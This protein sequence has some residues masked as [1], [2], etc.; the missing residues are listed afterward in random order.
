MQEV[1]EGGLISINHNEVE[2]VSLGNNL[3]IDQSIDQ[4]QELV[5]HLAACICPTL[6]PETPSPCWNLVYS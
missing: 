4:D 2:V 1:Q 6:I 5:H 3:V